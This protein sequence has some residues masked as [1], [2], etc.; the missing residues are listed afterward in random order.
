MSDSIIG[1]ATPRVDGAAKL[2]GRARYAADHHPEGMA[3]AYGVYSRISKGTIVNIDVAR[4]KG[5]P[6]VLDIFH[7]NNFDALH[8]SPSTFAEENM[9]D[10]L[11]LP[12]E[13]DHV[14]YAGQF[15]ALV[16][17]DTFE[18]ARAAA[19]RVQ[20]DYDGQSAAAN[21]AQASDAHGTV[22]ANRTTRGDP[23]G[24]F[25][26]AAHRIEATYT[27]PVETHNPMETHAT[28]ARWDQGR[29][30]VHESAQGVVFA[31]NTLAKVFD[32]D[33]SQVEVHAEYIG[34][35]FGGK[36]WLWPH[37]FATCVAAR[38]LE[39]PVQFVLPRQQMFTTAG[40]RP[41]TRQRMRLATD[42]DGKLV[43]LA[44]D[45]INTTADINTYRRSLRRLERQS[46]RLRQRARETRHGTGRPR[47]AHPNARAGRGRGP[48]RAG[49]GDGRDGR[50]DRHGSAG[51][52]AQELH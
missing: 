35:G 42:D 50:V 21:L 3:Y 27:T 16:V 1:A 14:H 30:I 48:V 28:V 49:I 32:L 37:C 39:R 52:P 51:V 10:E 12:F 34:S 47:H 29:L 40:H 6:G 15:V 31:R 19:Y 46:L 25:D 38:R 11:R 2:T 7:H 22:E 43:S 45:S 23:D 18:H 24:V 20:V 26:N 8:R 41:E 44:H 17:A 4:A 5:M 36:L 13:D 33:P 9:I